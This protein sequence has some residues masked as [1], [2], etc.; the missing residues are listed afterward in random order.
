MTRYTAKELILVVRSVLA[1]CEAYARLRMT[2]VSRI[3]DWATSKGRGQ[4]PLCDILVAFKRAASR[5]PATCLVR[6]L[7]LQHI[8]AQNGH[9]SELRIGVARSDGKLQGH[10]WLVDDNGQILIGAGE[11]AE[12]FALL[13]QWREDDQEGRGSKG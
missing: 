4:A 13:A 11:E 3:K 1:L 2:S 7:A 10:A 6:S 12:S 9:K 8:L 5:V